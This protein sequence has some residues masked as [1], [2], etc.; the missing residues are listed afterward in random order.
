MADNKI[1]RPDQ[2]VPNLGD[3]VGNAL[4]G[5]TSVFSVKPMAKYLSGARC[6]L[7]MNGKIV[8]FAFGISWKINTDATE[9]RTVDDYFPYELAPRHISVEGTISGFRIPGF[10]PTERL[11]QS[12]ALSFLHQRYIEIEVRDSQ[13]DNLIF[14]TRKAMVV[15]RSENI[16]S[17]SLAEMTLNFRAIGWADERTPDYLEYSS[18]K[19]LID[20][21]TV[22]VNAGR[23]IPFIPGELNN[24]IGR[25][26]FRGL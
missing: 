11:L 13:T 9:I 5:F 17:D 10:G 23:P 6:V 7:R 16:K 3:V 19:D 1:D 4:G 25:G 14:L 20:V 18:M 8:G 24:R 2:I 12:D 26:F 22:G 21:S 15:G